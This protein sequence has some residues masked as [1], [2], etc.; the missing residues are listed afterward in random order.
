VKP[1][2]VVVLSF[3]GVLLSICIPPERLPWNADVKVYWFQFTGMPSTINGYSATSSTG[4]SQSYELDGHGYLNKGGVTI[5]AHFY[6]QF[7][8]YRP[9]DTTA[10]LL[11]HERSH[12]D[13][14]E[15]HAR[16][17]RKRISEYAFT[18]NSKDEIKRL[19]DQVEKERQQM[20]MQ[21]DS[22]TNHSR[23]HTQEEIWHKVIRKMLE[24]YWV[25]TL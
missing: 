4:L 6:P 2:F 23:N 21:F 22:E 7:S 13:I 20:Q 3:V 15:I 5:T 14:T 11:S 9:K 17:L 16:K 19:Y 8:W 1:F 10:Y 18:S 25:Y 24:E 12:F